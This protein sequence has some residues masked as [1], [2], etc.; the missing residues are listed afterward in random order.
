MTSIRVRM[1]TG[2]PPSPLAG[3]GIPRGRI[4]NCAKF[5]VPT[6]PASA[7]HFARSTL[8]RIG[9]KRA[10][11]TGLFLIGLV[12]PALAQTATTTNPTV[13]TAQPTES[14]FGPQAAVTIKKLLADG[15]EIKTGFIDP[16]GG[17]YIAL[18]KATAAYFCHSNPNPTCE[19]LN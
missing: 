19:K 18:Q 13:T 15:F 9:G 11:I 17:A 2:T 1:S 14:S 3:E 10:A 8:S 4:R 6:C 12:P 7:S 16:N 5:R